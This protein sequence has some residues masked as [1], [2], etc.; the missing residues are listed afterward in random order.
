MKSEK[1]EYIRFDD[2]KTGILMGGKPYL[3]SHGDFSSLREVKTP[4]SQ[5]DL[6]ENLGQNLRYDGLVPTKDKHDAIQEFSDHIHPFFVDLKE[7]LNGASSE[8]VLHLEVFLNPSEL[9]LIP[10]ELLLDKN[11]APYFTQSE[12][13]KIVLTRN[14]RREYQKHNGKIPETP[15]VLYAHTKPKQRNFLDLPFPDVP[16]QEHLN[17]IEFSLGHWAKSQLTVLENPTFEEFKEEIYGA[18]KTNN[19]YTHIHLL[20]HGSLIF[21]PKNPANYEYGIAFVQKE[22]E[23]PYEATPTKEIKELFENLNPLHLPFLVNYM[24]CDA[25]NFTNGIKPDR[26]PV[27]ATFLAGVPIVLGS[28]FP[29]SQDGSNKITNLLYG[30][31]FRGEDI[32]KLLGDIRT[33][34]HKDQSRYGHDWISF[35]NYANLPENYEFQLLILKTKRQLSI[36]NAIRD[37]GDKTMFTKD[38][39]IGVKYQIQRSIKDLGSS[40]KRIESDQSKEKDFLEYAGL[41]GSAYKRLAEVEFEE[42]NVQGSDTLAKQLEYLEEA[43]TWYK[44][45]AKKNR[46][47]HWSIVQYLSLKTILDGGLDEDDMD[48]WYAARGASR[49]E[50]NKA[51]TKAT[52]PYGTLIELS[53]LNEKTT[54]AESKKSMLEFVDSLVKNANKQGL[55]EHIKSTRFQILR[56]MKWW[57]GPQFKI[58]QNILA[59]DSE[60]LNEIC[61]LLPE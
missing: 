36:L 28:Q 33:V 49:E 29:L 4:L 7:I 9:A 2:L 39:F 15:R 10:F 16:A 42:G 35:V 60:L 41:L 47:H 27:Q 30:P 25:A 59:Y 46:S 24:I 32:R 13:N 21:D 14:F 50:I 31:L 38:D 37:S 5:I 57:N 58:S 45:A 1:V 26:N 56:Y 22:T 8:D 12:E 54:D 6:L 34:L 61:T 20:A 44:K 51:K 19:P 52:W 48:Y 3:I 55:E 40:V 23:R 17:D 53:L 43:K 11:G 18:S